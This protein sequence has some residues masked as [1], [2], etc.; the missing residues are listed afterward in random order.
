[1]KSWLI[2]WLFFILLQTALISHPTAFGALQV[3]VFLFDVHDEAR[4]RVIP[5]KVYV[6]R[7]KRSRIPAVL[8][9]HGLG[10]SREAS[11]Y[12]GQY[13]ASAGYVAVF[14]QHPGS[15]ENIWKDAPLNKRLDALKQAVN[16]QALLQRIRDVSFIIDRLEQ[17][18]Q[19]KG[20]PLSGR[21]N[22]QKIGMSGH[23]FGAVTTQAVMGQKF[24]GNLHFNK[25]RLKAFLL[26]SPSA[27]QGMRPE[28]SFG[29]IQSP[30]MCMTGTEDHSPIRGVVTA[31]SRRKVFSALPAG[32]KFQVVFQG[33][34]HYTF[35]E[36]D[37]ADKETIDPRFHPAIQHLSTAFWD[38]YLKDDDKQRAYL[39]SNGP[40]AVLIKK[41]IWEWK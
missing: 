27:G 41:D 18:N 30:V 36:R 23:S 14:M 25:N 4:R 6:P 29:H 31:E 16:T 24:V 8:F 12:L 39:Q 38:A 19:E 34:H 1:M 13:W 9:S 3:E 17:W 37:M 5:I 33:G 40:R 11:S 15:D 35:S 28:E 22:I 26:F 32:D 20:H 2:I 21:L 10:G 7:E